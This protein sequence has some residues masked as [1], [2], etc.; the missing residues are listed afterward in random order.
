MENSIAQYEKMPSAIQ[1]ALISSM[2]LAISGFQQQNGMLSNTSA[3]MSTSEISN[4][5]SKSMSAT[6]SQSIKDLQ[7]LNKTIS[8]IN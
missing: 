2:N 3:A 5:A 4:A 1:S 8:N 6:F 7:L